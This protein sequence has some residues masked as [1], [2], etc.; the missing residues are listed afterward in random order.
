MK[1]SFDY[2][3]EQMVRYNCVFYARDCF[4][5]NFQLIFIDKIGLA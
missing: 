4:F 2:L 1:C 5:A 3:I